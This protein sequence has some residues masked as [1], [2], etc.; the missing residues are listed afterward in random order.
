M[1]VG[2]QLTGNDVDHGVRAKARILIAHHGNIVAPSF[3]KRRSARAGVQICTVRRNPARMNPVV[4]QARVLI[5][6]SNAR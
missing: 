4:W 6:I 3:I 5:R 2:N 1:T